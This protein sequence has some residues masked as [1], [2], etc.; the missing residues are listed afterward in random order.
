MLARGC[1]TSIA[2]ISGAAVLDRP[3]DKLLDRRRSL[4][5]VPGE[6]PY[7]HH[8]RVLVGVKEADVCRA[9][10][11]AEPGERL[12]DT[13]AETL[14]VKAVQHEQA[15]HEI[16]LGQLGEQGRSLD[17]LWSAGQL[18]YPREPL[19]VHGRQEPHQLLG[20]SHRPALRQRPEELEQLGDPFPGCCQVV[21]VGHGVLHRLARSALVEGMHHRRGVQLLQHVAPA[22]IHV[23]AQGRH[24]SKLLTD[25][26]MSMPLN[27]SSPFSSK[28]GQSW[29]AS[30]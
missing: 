25:R 2:C 1:S 21:G 7:P 18:E 9:E 3:A 12:L 20:P 29:T 23:D 4:A 11:S 22:E 6:E 30:S 28:I 19:P 13:G 16:V 26:M 15:R 10:R 14:G 8:S 27:E 24:G 17:R 5:S